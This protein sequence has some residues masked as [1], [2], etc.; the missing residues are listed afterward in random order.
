MIGFVSSGYQRSAEPGQLAAVLAAAGVRWDDVADCHELGG[1]TFNTV[2]RVRCA[3]GSGLV[4]KLAPSAGTPI[5]RYEQGILG[6]EALYYRRAADVAGV[7]V[8]AVV[9][10]DADGGQAGR[11][12]LVMSECAGTPWPEVKASLSGSERDEL[13]TELGRQVARLHTIT[14]EQFGYPAQKFAPLRP[15]W[16]T[17]FLDMVDAVLADAHGY[18]VALPR[19][20]PEMR[21]LFAAQAPV[22]DEVTTPVLVHFD[23]WDGNILIDRPGGAARIGGLIDAERAFWGDPLADFVSLAL[24]GDIEQDEAFLSGYRSTGAVATFDAAARQRLALYASYLYLLMWVESAPR[25]YDEPRC[26]WLQSRVVRPLADTLDA[27]SAQAG[28]GVIPRW[29]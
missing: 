14:G 23:L 28:R 19:P 16:R 17:A 20:G 5:L 26:A 27:W 11:A 8:P 2:Y 1:G 15:S 4:V 22:L 21:E 29:R 7:T 6:A 10:L 9:H 25:H 12:H 18:G 24:L 13:R 3:D